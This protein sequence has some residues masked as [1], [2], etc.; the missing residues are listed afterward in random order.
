MAEVVSL[1][2]FRKTKAKS[3]KDKKA[4]DNRVKFG[5]TKAQKTSDALER[6]T[7]DSDLDG[8]E[9]PENSDN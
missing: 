5:R 9:I 6:K 4:Q 2:Q 3:T 7:R 8:K 1:S